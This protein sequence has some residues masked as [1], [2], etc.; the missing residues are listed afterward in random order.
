MLRSFIIITLRILWRNKV[1]S[2]VNIFSL[3]IGITS[4]IFIMLYVHHET[5][6]DKFNKNYERIYRL[7]GD[8]YAKLPPVVG[9]FVKERLPEIE[10]VA[11]LSGYGKVN[12][13]Y[14]PESDPENVK[15]TNT[16]VLWAD[17]TTFDVFTLPIVHGNTS[18][19]LTHPFKAVITEET[20]EILFGT[21]DPIG[22]SIEFVG[23]PFE[24]TGI[25]RKPEKSHLEMDVLVSMT[26]MPLVYPDRDLNFTGGN[27][28]LW[29]ATYLLAASG[30]DEKKLEQKVNETLGEINNG[31]LFDTIFRQFHLRPLKQIYFNGALQNWDYGLHGSWKIISILFIVGVS[32][33]T[34]ACINYINLTT[35]R[36]I[37]RTKEVAVKRFVG[38]S[39]AMVRL[40]LI[41]ESV[42]VSVISL[43]VAL[44]L[45]QIF[46]R[47]FN[48]VAMANINL[49]EWNRPEVWI[50]VLT[51]VV[52]LG[53][54]AG[55]YP[56]FYLTAAKPIRL[57]KGSLSESPYSFSPR[58]L[59]MTFQ[60]TL[61][62]I[63]IICSLVNLRQLKYLSHADLGFNKEHII[64][65]ETPAE[66]KQEYALRETFR[67][68]LLQS[69]DILGVAY[70]AGSPGGLIPTHPIEFE[71]KQSTLDFFLVDQD[72]FNVMGIEI[73]E[74]RGLPQ[75]RISDTDVAPEKIECLVN[76]AFVREFDLDAPVGKTYYAD[77]PS[78]RHS[79]E[80]I[81][82]VRDFNIRSLHHKISPMNFIP[83]PPMALANI[84]V[85]TTDVGE[86]IHNL[87][88]TW[89][90]VYGD[91]FFTFSFL[92]ETIDRQYKN[93]EQFSKVINWFTGLALVI[94][95]LGLFALSSFTIIRRTKEIGIRKSLGASIQSIYTMLSWDFL[96]WIVL[97]VVLACP[98]SWYLMQLWLSKFAYHFK[99][100]WDIFII[101]SGVAFMVALVTITWQSLKAANANP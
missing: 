67:E 73:V 2:F 31:N 33:L 27:A 93:D 16:S 64:Q 76:E 65:I 92:D 13:F 42:M 6:Y 78:G 1:T 3:S 77:T 14:R 38:S 98:I 44:T 28:W 94:A 5:S 99:P 87:E 91:Q 4:F 8:D 26:S 45:V 88:K 63:L 51:A 69:P 18:S 39:V 17:S 25:I 24:V 71:N 32:M 41:L 82:V 101:A 59:L 22:K 83:A 35:A 49:A 90:K 43:V 23:H 19:P 89:K 70:S 54:V 40:Q 80:I 29:S 74:G 72:Y 9:D 20:A 68:E 62:V 97:A 12:V 58:S 55:I 47:I 52:L 66:F 53:I 95:C 56:A 84:K 81:G 7:E 61:S 37:T 10:N 50:I 30:T 96:K 60:F 100:G 48:D 34:L 57:M 11:H 79:F 85:Q 15:F 86:T 21:T 75:R 36:S 46:I